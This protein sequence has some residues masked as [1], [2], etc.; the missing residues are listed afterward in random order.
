MTLIAPVSVFADLTSEANA[1]FGSDNWKSDKDASFPYQY[2]LLLEDG[3]VKTIYL[4]SKPSVGD[5]DVKV[6][7]DG[8]LVLGGLGQGDQSTAWNNL[9]AR[10]KNFIVGISGIGAITMV[11]LFIIQFMKL[12]ASAGNPQARSAALSGV[13]WTGIAAAGLGAAAI[14]AGFAYNMI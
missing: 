9:F 2:E 3:T 10:Y 7:A 14:V 5:V 11:V 4:K 8:K 13:L 12:G 1:K 6:G